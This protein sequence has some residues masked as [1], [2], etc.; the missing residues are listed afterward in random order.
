MHE[1]DD[2]IIRNFDLTQLR[3]LIAIAE[4]PSFE[5]AAEKLHKSQPALSQHIQRLETQ[6]EAPLLVKSGRRKVLTEQGE[7]LLEYARRIIA[8][9]DEAWRAMRAPHVRGAIRFGVPPDIADAILPQ[10]LTKIAGRFPAVRLEVHVNRSPGLMESLLRGDI[11]LA[12][13]T[14]TH[15]Q[16]EHA[17]LFSLQTVWIC[18]AD[19]V[20]MPERPADL[21]LAD[22]PS[23]YRKVA[24]E[25][26]EARAMPWRIA[27]IAL[28]MMGIK[29]AVKA[30]LGVTARSVEFLTPEFRVLGAE[31]GF[32]ALRDIAYNLCLCRDA[33]DEHLRQ[34]FDALSADSAVQT[35]TLGS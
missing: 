6:L 32:P 1:S 2:P 13:T 28:N 9:N 14:R 24:L 18:A 12:V 15:A 20:Y 17:R 10:L 33:Q 19:Y 31:S 16:V 3:S 35:A 7:W 25:A 30:R 23:I 21:V 4:S 27:Y 5:H 11:D 22:E 26:L 29:A 8:I 34:V